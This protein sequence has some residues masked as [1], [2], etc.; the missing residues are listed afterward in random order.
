MSGYLWNTGNLTAG[1]A[2][3]MR[4]LPLTRIITKEY[5]YGNGSIY[6]K[7]IRHKIQDVLIVSASDGTAGSVYRNETPVAQE[8]HLS[9]C[10]KTMKSSYTWGGYSEEVVDA[11]FNTTSGPF[12]WQA[13]P[14]EDETGNYT[15]ILYMENITIKAEDSIGDPEPAHFGVSNATALSIMQGFTDIFP[16]YTTKTNESAPPILCFKTWKS[17]T[18]WHQTLFFNPW[19][20]PNNVTRHIERLATALTNVI[21]SAPSRQ[22]V[23][24]HAFSKDTFVSVR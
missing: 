14:Y 24:G 19:V 21:R 23:E 4:T 9:W 18:P 11:V 20:A 8:C 15:D 1:E 6:F 3:I 2:L 22:D 12:P 7:H 10:V 13:T 16:A 17:G 5:L